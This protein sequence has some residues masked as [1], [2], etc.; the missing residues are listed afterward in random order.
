M[1]TL[2]QEGGK[3][4]IL[5][6]IGSLTLLGAFLG[7]AAG[8]IIGMRINGSEEIRCGGEVYFGFTKRAVSF[9]IRVLLILLFTAASYKVLYHIAAIDFPGFIP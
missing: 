5:F 7:V 3:L 8:K 1:G 6:G 9:V 2:Y 4:I